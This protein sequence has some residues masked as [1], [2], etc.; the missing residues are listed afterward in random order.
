MRACVL[1]R[2][3]PADFIAAFKDLSDEV[4]HYPWTAFPW[5]LSFTAGL[6]GNG[7]NLVR[8]DVIQ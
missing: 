1:T 7:G 5:Q 2:M 4:T 8:R 3:G 6:V